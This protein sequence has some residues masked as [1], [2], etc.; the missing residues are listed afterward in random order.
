MKRLCFA[1]ASAAALLAGGPTLRADDAKPT[2][3]LRVESIDGLLKNAEYIAELAGQKENA[4]QFLGIVKSMTDP[5][6]GL[7]GIDTGRPI[8][9]FA[10][11]KGMP[12]EQPPAAFAAQQQVVALVPVADQEAL[13]NF[14][15]RFGIEPQKG[16]DGVYTVNLPGAPVAVY[17]RFAQKYACVTAMQKENISEKNLPDLAKALELPGHGLVDLV[18]NFD[19][20]PPELR[21]MALGQLEMKLAEAKQE[22]DPGDT[23]AEHALKGEL[24]DSL[25]GGAKML[26][27]GA[28]TLHLSLGVDQ[29]AEELRAGASLTGMEGT[30]LARRFAALGKRTSATLAGLREKGNVFLFNGTYTLPDSLRDAL[31]RAYDTFIKEASRELARKGPEKSKVSPEAVEALLASLKPTIAA[32]ES[33]GGYAMYGPNADGKYTVVLGAKVRQGRGIEE[34]VRKVVRDLPPEVQKLV[35]FDAGKAGGANL[36]QVQLP[37]KAFEDE[38]VRQLFGENASVWLAV[39]DDR[40]WGAFGTDAEQAVKDL[41][42]TKPAPAPVAVYEVRLKGLVPLIAREHPG[43]TAAAKEAFGEGARDADLVRLLIEGGDKL[44]VRLTVGARII[45][46]GAKMAQAE[47]GSEQ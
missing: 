24:L 7:E 5:V 2:L 21:K 9:L 47:R 30:E 43:A 45:A 38:N 23:D 29:R 31:G 44:S 32:G 39:S 35:R 8:G 28:G 4:D 26:L 42:G 13:L 27:E 25:V 1:L 20:I 19:T 22:R 34:A 10:R 15:G 33:D 46:F 40:I 18:V 37:P 14:F 3:L 12:G 16:D 17:F 11:M 6:K 36:H 41:L